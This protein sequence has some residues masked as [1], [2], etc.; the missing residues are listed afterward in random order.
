[1]EFI[2]KKYENM[3]RNIITEGKVPET[4]MS[5]LDIR[6]SGNRGKF[7]SASEKFIAVRDAMASR[8]PD[9][10][11]QQFIKSVTP[12]DF[13]R[14]KKGNRD[15]IIPEPTNNTT[16]NYQPITPKDRA[17]SIPF[18]VDDTGVF[19]ALDDKVFKQHLYPAIIQYYKNT[20]H[21][22]MPSRE[23][24]KHIMWAHYSHDD[25]ITMDD[26]LKS[27]DKAHTDSSVKRRIDDDTIVQKS[28]EHFG[29]KTKE[30]MVD[31]LANDYQYVQER[32][33]KQR[34]QQ[35]LSNPKSLTHNQFHQDQRNAGIYRPLLDDAKMSIVKAYLK[36]D[37]KALDRYTKEY[38]LIK[39]V[40]KL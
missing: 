36:R 9:K 18:V 29:F 5:G 33:S 15:M 16:N 8:T 11:M 20:F 28:V 38:Q 26:V 6:F 35:S 2:M 27:L 17:K 14:Y 25:D 7:K 40:F 39:H 30:E 4:V 34:K 1:M 37:A 19:K 23:L 13:F 12:G 21:N 31:A 3:L 10:E 32:I 22:S 24:A